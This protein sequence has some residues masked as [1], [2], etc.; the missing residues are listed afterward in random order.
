MF[1][2]KDNSVFFGVFVT[3]FANF[4][5]LPLK[6]PLEPVMHNSHLNIVSQCRTNTQNVGSFQNTYIISLPNGPNNRYPLIP[7]GRYRM[8][9]MFHFKNESLFNYTTEMEIIHHHATIWWTTQL[10]TC[11][12]WGLT[13]NKITFQIFAWLQRIK[14]CTTIV[15]NRVFCTNKWFFRSLQARN[16]VTVR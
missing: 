1:E 7:A 4:T 9:N 10:I 12:R 5:N 3:A 6:C 14:M 15:Q 11:M 16:S 8:I 2:G 13:E